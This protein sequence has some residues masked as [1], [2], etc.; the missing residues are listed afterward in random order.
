MSIYEQFSAQLVTEGVITVG[1]ALRHLRE[2]YDLL[3]V[4]LLFGF[5][6]ILWWLGID[7]V[8]KIR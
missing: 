1:A 6:V 8:L 2:L 4:V 7:S 5:V 3:V